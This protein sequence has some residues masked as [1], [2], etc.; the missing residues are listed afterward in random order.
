MNK[1]NTLEKLGTDIERLRNMTDDDIDFSDIPPMTEEMWKNGVVRRG[2]QI[3][4]RKDQDNVPIDKD[5]IE[6]FKHESPIYPAAINRLLR[7][8]MEARRAK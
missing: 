5:I 7:E 1:K 2:S 8:Y 3:I 6:F 4:P